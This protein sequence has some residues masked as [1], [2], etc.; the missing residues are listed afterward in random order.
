MAGELA[1]ERARLLLSPPRSVTVGERVERVAAL[2]NAI[3]LLRHK[4]AI[5][6]DQYQAALVD[7]VGNYRVT[8]TPGGRRGGDGQPG[9]AG[10]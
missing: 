6:P 7:T 5:S 10:A 9:R 2:D 8:Q 1:E 3:A 4:R